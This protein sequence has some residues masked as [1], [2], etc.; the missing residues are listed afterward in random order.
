MSDEGRF[1]DAVGSSFPMRALF[2][3]LERVAPTDQ[4]VLLLGESGTGKE[5]LARSL[6]ARSPRNDGPFVVFDCGSTTASLVESEL[7]GHVKGAFTGAA[8]AHEGLLEQADG[9][10]LF[11]DEIGELP[12]DLQP[13]LLR[14][15]E[16]RK[17]RRLGSAEW[18]AFDTRVVA[19]THRDLRARVA[20]GTFREDLYYRLAVVEVRVPALRERKEDIP[21]LVERFLAA[22]APPLSLSH[23]PP[24]ALKMLAGHDWPGN[25]RELRNV[26]ERLVLFPELAD[27]ALGP[28][29]HAASQTSQDPGPSIDLANPDPAQVLA[30]LDDLERTTAPLLR[31]P[32]QVARDALTEPFE[33]V[34]ITMKLRE[35]DGNVSDAADSMGLSRS[36][37]YRLL[38]RY[39][40]R[41]R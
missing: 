23:L 19:A 26:V 1:G 17:S 40:M 39:D 20:E 13:K 15:L 8:A 37:L 4:T 24:H 3:T 35:H 9:G 16:D 2:A 38:D 28:L 32:L 18:K 10:T 14:A 41:P 33:R 25:V 11:I 21:S 31:L 7:F 34:F 5:V 36:Q 29:S 27:K 12:L 6:H 22:R 30:V